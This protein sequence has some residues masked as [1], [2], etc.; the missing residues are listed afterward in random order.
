MKFLRESDWQSSLTKRERT[1][2]NS[3]CNGSRENNV[4]QPGKGRLQNEKQRRRHNQSQTKPRV[5][6]VTTD[7]K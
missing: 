7:A 1:G 3:I 2:N 6:K 5:Q 4:R